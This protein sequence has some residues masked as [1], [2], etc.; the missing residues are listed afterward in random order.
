MTATLQHAFLRD[1]FYTLSL[2]GA[3]GH[4]GL[5]RRDIGESDPKRKQ[6]RNSLKARLEALA[7]SYGSPIS[8]ADHLANI[9]RL[10][11]ELSMNYHEY[12]RDRRFRIGLAQKALNLYLKYLWCAGFAARPPHCPV[13]AIIL[14]AAGIKDAT[15]WTKLDSIEEY[16]RLIERL[17]T[18]AAGQP[19]AEWELAQW[20]AQKAKAPQRR[21]RSC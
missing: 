3:L 14:A 10:A 4:A 20:S 17:R 18:Q 12:F 2:L 13:D 1:E 11:D 9:N 6:F 21:R 5:W 7:S 19:L 15:P 16:A 8:D